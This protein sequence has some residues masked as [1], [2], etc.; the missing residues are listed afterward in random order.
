MPPTGCFAFRLLRGVVSR[1]LQIF[2]ANFKWSLGDKR[3]CRSQ[4]TSGFPC[5]PERE[6]A[7]GAVALL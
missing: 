6:R 1:W 4:P 2:K 7:G 5:I 3:I